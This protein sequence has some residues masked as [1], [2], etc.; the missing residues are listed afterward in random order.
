M[1]AVRGPAFLPADLAPAEG[2]DADDAGAASSRGSAG[3]GD[4]GAGGLGAAWDSP[5]VSVRLVDDAVVVIEG[6]E[7]VAAGEREALLRLGGAASQQVLAAARAA[8]RWD[9]YILP[10]LVDIHCHGGG[11][12]SFPDAAT[13]DE[14]MVA[15]DEHLRHGTT[16]LVASLVTDEPDVLARQ[17]A[18]LAELCRSGALAGIH[19]EGP[20]LS[21]RRAGAQDPAKMQ[22][23]DPGLVRRLAQAAGGWMAVMTVAPELPGVVTGRIR[24]SGAAGA[25][26]EGDPP[27]GGDP[28]ESVVAALAR[29]GA[30][31]SFGHTDCSAEQMGAA[32]AA[33][34]AALAAAETVDAG[35]APRTRTGRVAT[36]THLFNGMRPIH[37]RDPGPVME[38]LAQAAAGAMVVELI[39]DGVHLDPRT[40]KD[41]F[42]LVGP[43]QIAL[44]T[45]AMAAAGMPDGAYQLGPA[46][47]TVTDGVARLTHGGSIAGGTAHLIDVVRSAWQS[48]GVP[49]ADAVAAATLTPA[50]VLGASSRIGLLAR[51]RAADLVLADADLRPRQVYA[52]GQRVAAGPPPPR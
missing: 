5:A 2:G 7:I 15:V 6:G 48:G 31:A 43:G 3:G 35:Q 26:A 12:Q 46:A 52:H 39:A 21:P 25:S 10:G 33:A 23:P 50:R 8:R 36:A 9:G 19:F 45:D 28:D 44:V 22:A 41:V 4:C 14:A 29:V 18:L 42:S 17:A 49:L 38:A 47:V 30:V 37:H 51:G 24:D 16:S 32:V 11:G 13:T 34:D 1:W 40:A 20:F 27:D